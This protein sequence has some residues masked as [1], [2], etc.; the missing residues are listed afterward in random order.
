MITSALISQL[1]RKYNDSPVKHEDIIQ[2][3]GVSTV[4]RTQYYPILEGSF[5]LYVANVLKTET[6]DYTIDLDTGDISLAAPT[7]DE[8]K[9]QYQEARFRDQHW[10]EAIQGTFDVLGDAYF[11]SVIR[12]TSGITLSAGVQV[13]DCPSGC[14]RMT[15]V[16]EST[17]Y[18]SAGPFQEINTNTRYDRR[19]NKLI[20]GQSPSRANYLQISYLKKLTRPT[21]TSSVLD[22]EDSWLELVNL[23]AGADFLRSMA[24]RFALQGNATVEEGYF[25]T[26]QMR[27]LANDNE[28]M[29]ENKKSKLKPIMPAS[30]IPYYIHGGGAV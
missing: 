29:F 12:S 10:L 7:S 17:S 3:D 6:T 28:I 2:G 26:A 21:A 8:I 16:L 13:Y 25:S 11:R 24:S 5:K 22:L 1:R 9:V 18:T 30:K 20:L 19:S 27:Q 23:K 4:Y 15:E 14:I